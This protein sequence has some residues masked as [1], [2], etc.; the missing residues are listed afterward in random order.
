MKLTVLFAAV[1]L[2]T[3][4]L[5]AQTKP[6]ARA[7][8][9][10]I[11]EEVQRTYKAKDYP[12]LLDAAK[13][14]V[15]FTHGNSRWVLNLAN[16]YA[17]AGRKDDA[18]RT[19]QRVAEMG[20][21]ASEA[22]KD[23]DYASLHSDPRW[24]SITQ[25]FAN[26]NKKSGSSRP[27]ATFEDP[28]LL[29]EDIAWSRKTGNFYLTSVRKKKILR[30][31]RSSEITTLTDLSTDPGWPLFAIVADDN[32]GALWVTAAAIPDFAPAPK[33]DHGRSTLLEIDMNTGKVRHRYDLPDDGTPHV[34]G[35]AALTPTGDL[36]ISDGL[37]GAV[38][39][40]HEGTF[41]RIDHGEFLSP[42]TPAISDKGR[43]VVPDYVRGLALLNPTSPKPV[44]W[45]ANSYYSLNGI[46]GLYFS[47]IGQEDEPTLYAV[48]NGVSPHRISTIQL[49]S[50]LNV[51]KSADIV[52]SKNPELGEP[53]HGVF[54]DAQIFYFIANSG[55]DQ[56][57]DNGRPKSDLKPTP[58]AIR[59]LRVGDSSDLP[60]LP[61]RDVH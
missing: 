42:Q 13:R 21:D 51:V 9:K 49:N 59:E 15:E 7:T 48:Q 35:D 25:Q 41:A 33:A 17:L 54:T 52:L 20:I 3:S 44:T 38:Y 4:A 56:L 19:L 28:E 24:D 5:I 36:I 60:T 22:L 29:T 10:S 55:W 39:H 23:N 2:G 26:A 53:T 12:A 45:I 32:R 47:P 18:F 16:C 58:P 8:Y 50:R 34:L 61:R 37:N 40:F 57:D 43:I 1:L 27:I 31:A 46:D 30:V 6:D 11:R 14:A